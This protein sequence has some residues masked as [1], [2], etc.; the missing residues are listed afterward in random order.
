MTRSD[1]RLNAISLFSGAMGLDLG[2]EKAG[3]N[4]RVCIEKDKEAARTIRLNTSIP[5]I[6]EP[7]RDSGAMR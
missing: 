7:L 3:F 1:M 4:I 5:V 6:E 2:F